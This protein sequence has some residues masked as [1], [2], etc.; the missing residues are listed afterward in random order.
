MFEDLKIIDI[1]EA[2]NM[3]ICTRKKVFIATMTAVALNAFP[4]HSG[5]IEIVGQRPPRDEQAIEAFFNAL[6]QQLLAAQLL[7]LERSMRVEPTE[8][9]NAEPKA[10]CSTGGSNTSHTVFARSLDAN[11]AVRKYMRARL[12]A[13]FTGSFSGV[14]VRVIYGNGSSEVW[15]ITNP[16]HPTTVLDSDP[17]AGTQLPPSGTMVE[18]CRAMS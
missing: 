6:E 12:A 16:F 5:R 14:Q 13:G 7:E 3:M 9:A 1:K 8:V 10:Q 15:T 18:T 4:V 11:E 2:T 17:V